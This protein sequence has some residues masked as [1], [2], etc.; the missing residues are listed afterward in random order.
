MNQRIN[1][2]LSLTFMTTNKLFSAD[3]DNGKNQD[4]T[5]F[6][7]LPLY[8]QESTSSKG[9]FTLRVPPPSLLLFFYHSGSPKWKGRSKDQ[10]MVYLGRI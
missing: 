2:A 1:M 3:G 7:T 4:I 8:L 5:S 10:H 6:F 9:S